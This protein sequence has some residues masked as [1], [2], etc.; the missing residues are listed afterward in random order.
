MIE[1]GV[2]GGV[3]MIILCFVEVNNFYIEQNYN[4]S[5]LNVYFG[6]FDMNNLYGGV[7]IE[8][9]FVRDFKWLSVNEILEFDIMNVDKNVKNGYIL[10][11]IFEYLSYLYDVY[12]DLLLV[13][14]LLFIIIEDL[15]FYC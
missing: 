15:F 7:M 8:F 1:K 4:L 11:V 14:E 13:L 3:V 9:F 10:E 2:C 5:K 12:N 6:Y